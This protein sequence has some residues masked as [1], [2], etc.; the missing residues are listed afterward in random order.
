[1]FSIHNNMTISLSVLVITDLPLLVTTV[2]GMTGWPEVCD[3]KQVQLFF[4]FATSL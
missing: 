2:V 3:Y 4:D 1:M